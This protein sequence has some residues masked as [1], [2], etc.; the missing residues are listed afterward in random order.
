MAKQEFVFQGAG[1]VAGSIEDLW[2]RP[3]FQLIV[4]HTSPGALSPHNVFSRFALHALPRFSILFRMHGANLSIAVPVR[5]TPSPH[6]PRRVSTIFRNRALSVQ[7][8]RRSPW[9]KSSRTNAVPNGYGR[10]RSAPPSSCTDQPVRD[11]L[12]IPDRVRGGRVRTKADRHER[13]RLP[14]GLLDFP[15]ELL[16][17]KLADLPKP[18]IHA[19]KPDWPAIIR[20]LSPTARKHLIFMK[21]EF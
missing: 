5:E 6:N 4:T 14:Q 3:R 10:M 12:F 18:Q 7:N 15:A 16:P 20:P 17:C 21:N 13:A 2:R 8:S 11:R 9:R 1:D 19:I